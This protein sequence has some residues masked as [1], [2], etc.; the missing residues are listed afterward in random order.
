MPHK[1]RHR[2]S[3]SL[4]VLDLRKSTQREKQRRVSHSL[5]RLL[6]LRKSTQREKQRLRSTRHALALRRPPNHISCPIFL[7]HVL[8]N[9]RVHS[10]T[11]G[12]E[13]FGLLFSVFRMFSVAP[14]N[15][16][17]NNAFTTAAKFL[18]GHE[19][20]R[21]RLRKQNASRV[22]PPRKCFLLCKCPCS[23]W[24][25]GISNKW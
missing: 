5:T 16:G 1:I 20:W 17:K 21:I 15:E 22:F 2:V 9:A 6:K 23:F 4:S 24:L 14:I 19:T 13:T 25:G 11:G 3:H 7:K 18:S 8:K 12:R 10:I